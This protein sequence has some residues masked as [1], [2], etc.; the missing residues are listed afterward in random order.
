MS[1]CENGGEEK[2][3]PCIQGGRGKAAVVMRGKTLRIELPQY[4]VTLNCFAMAMPEVS[5]EISGGLT[6][7]R[8]DPEET[9]KAQRGSRTHARERVMPSAFIRHNAA[10]GRFLNDA[11]ENPTSDSVRLPALL[12]SNLR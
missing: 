6:S 3:T 4:E 9:D 10:H 7:W 5:I 12:N 2:A 1:K 11:T 8:H